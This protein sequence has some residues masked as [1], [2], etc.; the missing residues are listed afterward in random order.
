[1]KPLSIIFHL[2][3]IAASGVS[4][5][6]LWEKLSCIQEEKSPFSKLNIPD[7][8]TKSQHISISPERLLFNVIPPLAMTPEQ[9]KPDGLL[10]DNDQN[11]KKNVFHVKGIFISDSKRF[12]L[13]ESDSRMG[14][15]VELQKVVEG[16]RMDDFTVSTIHPRDVS[17]KDTGSGENIRLKVF[18]LA[19]ADQN[20][21]NNKLDPNLKS[22][23]DSIRKQP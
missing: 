8:T 6:G 12:A 20:L 15:A 5:Y 10:A 2:I 22:T 9:T 18:A 1:M 21:S 7:V 19:G 13:I 4:L 11:R 14:G 16:T 3:I 23:G 17:L